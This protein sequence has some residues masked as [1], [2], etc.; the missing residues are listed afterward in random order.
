ME[1]G[2][3]PGYFI[4]EISRIIP[5]GKLILTDIQEEMI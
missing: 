2:S 1:V 4:A 5:E 3:G